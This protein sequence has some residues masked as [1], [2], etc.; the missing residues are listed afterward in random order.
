MSFVSGAVAGV[1]LVKYYDA[2]QEE[3]EKQE[4]DDNDTRTNKT[5]ATLMNS[6]SG[7]YNESADTTSGA[8]HVNFLSDIVARLWPY[9]NKAHKWSVI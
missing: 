9:I 4:D 2:K 7:G 3:D 6:T 1:G 8:T 5:D